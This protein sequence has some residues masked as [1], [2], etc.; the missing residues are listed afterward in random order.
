MHLS[1]IE[2]IDPERV[3]VTIIETVDAMILEVSTLQIGKQ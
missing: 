1:T 3:I 2:L